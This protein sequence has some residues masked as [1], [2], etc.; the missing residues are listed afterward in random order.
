MGWVKTRGKKLIQSSC[1]IFVRYQFF[2]F[3]D[4]TRNCSAIAL[5]QVL[6]RLPKGFI[7]TFPKV[8]EVD[9]FGLPQECDN[10]V[11]HISVFP[12]QGGTVRTF[13]KP[14]EGISP[15]YG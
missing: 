14:E 1:L 5:V 10:L 11:S 13:G 8:P 6:H 12:S 7:P 9:L 3:I 15:P 4:E 2:A